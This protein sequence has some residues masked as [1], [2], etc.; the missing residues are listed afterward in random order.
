M[1]NYVLAIYEVEIIPIP[2]ESSSN[3]PIGRALTYST[4]I[5]VEGYSIN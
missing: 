5:E 3:P 4:I 2:L 1:I